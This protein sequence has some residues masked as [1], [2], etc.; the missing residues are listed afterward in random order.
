MFN[1]VGS[2]RAVFLVL[3][4]AISVFC[5]IAERAFIEVGRTATS[6]IEHNQPNGAANRSI[7]PIAG[8]EGID[9]PIHTDLTRD[10]TVDDYQ[11]RSHVGRGLYAIEVERGIGQS[12]HSGPHYG[13][14]FGFATSHDHVDGED[15]ASQ[16]TPARCDLALDKVCIAA[17]GLHGGVNFVLRG[18][19]DR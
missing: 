16:R 12:Q 13:R 10:R 6:D 17:K 2:E 9:A 19:D 7:R 18:W 11:R 15:L 4:N 8:T 3:A 5:R 14:V 1:L